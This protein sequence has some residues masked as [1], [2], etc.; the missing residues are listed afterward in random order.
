MG[1]KHDD[2]VVW[3]LSAR[4]MKSLLLIYTAQKTKFGHKDYWQCL[5]DIL[6]DVA[7][8]LVWHRKVQSEVEMNRD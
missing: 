5:W 2:S 1:M 3:V 6:V 4:L 7:N 8:S